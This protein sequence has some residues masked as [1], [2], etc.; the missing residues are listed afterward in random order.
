MNEDHRCSRCGHPLPATVVDTAAAGALIAELRREIESL[1]ATVARLR[2]S[3]CDRGPV[4][5]P[6]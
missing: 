5:R 6:G 2:G 3:G 4:R 1:C